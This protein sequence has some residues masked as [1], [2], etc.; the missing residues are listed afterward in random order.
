MFVQKDVNFEDQKIFV[1]TEY[2][3]Y[4]VQLRAIQDAHVNQ[5]SL[6]YHFNGICS[7][8]KSPR[9]RYVYMTGLCLFGTS[10]RGITKDNKDVCLSRLMQ[11]KSSCDVIHSVYKSEDKSIYSS[12][13]MNEL[14]ISYNDAQYYAKSI[15][16]HLIFYVHM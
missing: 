7:N 12:V 8:V 11:Q 10:L 4:F 14:E 6:F 13:A 15:G 16:K 5:R 1:D 2:G 9:S 3:R